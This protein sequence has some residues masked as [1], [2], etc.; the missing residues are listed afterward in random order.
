ML[1]QVQSRQEA[2]DILQNIA[3]QLS[4]GVFMK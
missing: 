3:E 4:Q 2:I 1:A